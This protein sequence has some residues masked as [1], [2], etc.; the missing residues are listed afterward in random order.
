MFKKLILVV[1][2]CVVSGSVNAQKI[3]HLDYDSLIKMMPETKTATEAAEKYLEGLRQ[4]LSAMQ[5]EFDTK[6]QEYL[7]NEATMSNLVKDSKRKDLEQL[8]NHIQE[9]QSQAEFD[10]KMKYTQ[11]TTPIMEK[12]K[13]GINAVAKEG[14][15]KYVLDTSPASTM[16][17]YSE[18]SDDI[19][20]AVKKKLD[21][22]P[23]AEIPGAT[24]GS[25]TDNK[26]T[27]PKT[28]GR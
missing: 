25:P 14:G 26:N 8:Q 4:E 11:L 5:A 12:A 18:T 20:M 7:K 21:S 1:A 9:F 2:V 6:Y 16:V 22:M 23:R 15:Y 13:K 24:Q 27:T 28:G 3:A 10:Y 17:L 19:L